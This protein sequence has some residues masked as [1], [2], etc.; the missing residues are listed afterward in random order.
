MGRSKRAGTSHGGAQGAPGAAPAVAPGAQFSTAGH[1]DTGRRR[2]SRNGA[3][4][5]T[6]M[7]RDLALEEPNAQA[8]R[9]D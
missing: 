8:F 5:E 9:L 3:V 7:H 4:V 2:A 1:I 6:G